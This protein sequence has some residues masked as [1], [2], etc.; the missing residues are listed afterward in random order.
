MSNLVKSWILLGLL[1]EM[2]VKACLPVQ[3]WHKDNF[4]AK[5]HPN[6]IDS[7]QKLE[8]WFT[9]HSLQADW[10]VASIIPGYCVSQSRLC[11]TF[12]LKLLSESLQFIV[13][14]WA[15]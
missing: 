10:Q 13:D 9:L 5:A 4:I 7:S 11:S 14:E 2:S 1:A 3:K 8:T 6:M 15:A 12:V